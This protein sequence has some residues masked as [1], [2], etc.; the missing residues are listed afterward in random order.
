VQQIAAIR[1]RTCTLAAQFNEAFDAVY[2]D[3]HICHEMLLEH[4]R[5]IF[6]VREELVALANKC[7]ADQASADARRDQLMKWRYEREDKAYKE[8]V[9]RARI[10]GKKIPTRRVRGD[11]P[12]EREEQKKHQEE[13][14]RRREE[15]QAEH[16]ELTREIFSCVLTDDEIPDLLFKVTEEEINKYSNHPYASDD[17]RRRKGANGQEKSIELDKEKKRALQDFMDGV[18]RKPGMV[19]V[20]VVDVEREEWMLT[21]D[22]HDMTPEQKQEVATLDEKE[23]KQRGERAAKRREVLEQLRKLYSEIHSLL[24]RFD[25]KLRELADAKFH[26]DQVLERHNYLCASLVD[27][28]SADELGELASQ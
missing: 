10:M 18:L 28:M 1:E 11:S 15:E 5:R 17:R 13:L 21:T 16:A 26:L 7:R 20:E 4:R 8:S 25:K 22:P 12:E 9:I 2:K 19:G 6:D 24:D 23:A 27:S 3:K 14:D